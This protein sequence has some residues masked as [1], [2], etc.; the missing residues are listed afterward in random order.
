MTPL[1]A[2]YRVKQFLSIFI[3][4]LVINC[5]LAILRITSSGVNNRAQKYYIITLWLMNFAN[6]LSLALAYLGPN[7]NISFY[8]KCLPSYVGKDDQIGMIGILFHLNSTFFDKWTSFLYFPFCLYQLKLSGGT[9]TTHETV[10]SLFLHSEDLVLLNYCA[11][12]YRICKWR[13]V[14]RDNLLQ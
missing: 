9:E 2:V 3:T 5:L 1:L 4:L 6:R 11:V 12:Y 10:L 8:K 7:G 14:C 13:V